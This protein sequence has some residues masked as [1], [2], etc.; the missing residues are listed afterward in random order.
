MPRRR[1]RS[2][3]RARPQHSSHPLRFPLRRRRTRR[4]DPHRGPR[5]RTAMVQCRRS[6]TRVRMDPC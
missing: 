4:R 2:A 6:A 3:Q 1:R 5:A